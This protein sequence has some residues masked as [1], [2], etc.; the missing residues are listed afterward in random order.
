MDVGV[1][2]A[3]RTEAITIY[4]K[5]CGCPGGG[6]YWPKGVLLWQWGDRAGDDDLV[7]CRECRAVWTVGEVKC[8][9]CKGSCWTLDSRGI[10]MCCEHCE[11][12]G[13]RT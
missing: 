2:F 9:F 11:G 5:M 12:T 6:H 3:D 13:F 8:G 7:E 1:T 4:P 10:D